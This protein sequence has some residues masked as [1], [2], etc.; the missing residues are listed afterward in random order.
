MITAMLRFLSEVRAKAGPWEPIAFHTKQYLALRSRWIQHM[1]GEEGAAHTRCVDFVQH[2][3][4]LGPGL[5]SVWQTTPAQEF[6]ERD[7]FP[8]GQTGDVVSSETASCVANRVSPALA[9][10]ALARRVDELQAKGFAV[11]SAELT[12]G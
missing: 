8:W 6:G 5:A 1:A 3:S 10:E 7:P 12:D 4:S 9:R 11:V 2:Y